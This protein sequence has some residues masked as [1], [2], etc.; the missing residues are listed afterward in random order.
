ML[1]FERDTVDLLVAGNVD[2]LTRI[3]CLS[4]NQ[5]YRCDLARSLSGLSCQ[6]GHDSSYMFARRPD[7]TYFGPLLRECDASFRGVYVST[8][9]HPPIGS[10]T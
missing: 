1:P 6:Y 7:E 4:W 3:S 5:S 10:C 2:V 8:P 9:M